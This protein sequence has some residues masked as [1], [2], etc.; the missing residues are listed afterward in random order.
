MSWKDLRSR[1]AWR[2]KR[3]LNVVS[4]E[5]ALQA[6]ATAG[7]GQ[8]DAGPRGGLLYSAVMDLPSGSAVPWRHCSLLSG[9]GDRGGHWRDTRLSTQNNPVLIRVLE[10]RKIGG[11][12]FLSFSAVC[13]LQ[14]RALRNSPYGCPPSPLRLRSLAPQV[15]CWRDK[16]SPSLS[17]CSPLRIGA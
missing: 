2:E 11:T 5:Q 14:P 13:W 8:V 7:Y 3:H 1:L 15:I 6:L 17:P 9:W 12:V 4:A 10:K 16:G